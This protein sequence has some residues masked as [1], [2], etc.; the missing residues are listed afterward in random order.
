VDIR[1]LSTFLEVSRTRHFG[2]AAENLYLTQS[3]VS[4]RI[5]LLEEYFKTALFI[6]NRNSIQITPAGEKLIP[7]A[8]KMSTTLAEARNSLAQE[9]CQHV[10][11]AST[12]NA[13]YL[14][15]SALF[16]ELLKN[17]PALSI[18]HEILSI[19]QVTRQL[20]EQSIDFAITTTPVK[21]DDVINQLLLE[22]P[23]A[24]YGRKK[25]LLTELAE[26]A[27]FIHIDWGTSVNDKLFGLY[28]QIKQAKAKTASMQVGLNMLQ[29]LSCYVLL[30]L[31]SAP[32]LDSQYKATLSQF[33]TQAAG[34]EIK[35]SIYLNKLKGAVNKGVDELT[36]NIIATINK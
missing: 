5:K 29:S 16:P 18:R 26:N 19:E 13:Y 15:F 35:L 20:H 8:E 7:F 22:V 32:F 4:A 34:Q 33:D 10:N 28:P 2:H 24:L 30:P 6:R 25:T 17:V 27:A 36:D 23:L 12:E 1:F 9:E 14:L 31:H 11:C 21:S 3:A